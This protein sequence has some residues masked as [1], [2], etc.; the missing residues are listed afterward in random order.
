MPSLQTNKTEKPNKE[1]LAPQ[2]T[3]RK[4]F[5]HKHYQER[6]ERLKEKEKITKGMVLL[7]LSRSNKG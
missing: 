5:A 7:Y 6:R 4:K 3:K 1:L 2:S